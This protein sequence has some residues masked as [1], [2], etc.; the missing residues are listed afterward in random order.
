KSF[1]ERGVAGNNPTLQN[2]D[3]INVPRLAM[4]EAYLL[5]QLVRPATIDLTRED[6]TLTQAVTRVGGLREDQADARGIFV[7][8][9]TDRGIT[10][11]QLDA[12]NPAAFLLGTRFTLAPR[13]VVYV[14]TAP[15]YRWNRL[16]SSLLPT[17]GLARTV[18]QIQN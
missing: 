13:D 5:G 7:F 1:L 8:R 9:A 17:L 11:Y 18:D 6:V 14:T 2:G 10:V 16:I 4:A 3:V 15:L 12:S